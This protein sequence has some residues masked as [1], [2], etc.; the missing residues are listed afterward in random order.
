MMYELQCPVCGGT[1]IVE[2]NLA[3]VEYEFT[4]KQKAGCLLMNYGEHSLIEDTAEPM[5]YCFHCKDC[6]C[7]FDFNLFTK[8]YTVE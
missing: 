7:R 2:D 3:V 4:I 1:N 5:E 8:E 6:S